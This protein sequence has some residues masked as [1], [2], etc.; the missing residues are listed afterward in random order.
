MLKFEFIAAHC[1]TAPNLEPQKL[2][3]AA[4]IEMGSVPAFDFWSPRANVRERFP[5]LGEA[6]I[7]DLIMNPR[8]APYV[9]KKGAN[10][11]FYNNGRKNVL[12]HPDN[13]RG[14]LQMIAQFVCTIRTH[15]LVSGVRG[16]CW[17]QSS[18]PE[19]MSIGDDFGPV[20]TITW[21]TLSAAVFEAEKR[22][23]T[24]KNVIAAIN[25]GTENCIVCH[26]NL[27]KDIVEFLRDFHNKWHSGAATTFVQH[28]MNIPEIDAQLHRWCK[29]HGYTSRSCGKGTDS[30]R[31]RQWQYLSESHLEIVGAIEDMAT[32]EHARTCVNYFK[33]RNWLDTFKNHVNAVTFFDSFRGKKD[34]VKKVISCLHEFFPIFG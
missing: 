25:K 10:I 11:K 20:Y 30:F 1:C 16:Q 4:P 26:H 24:E 29:R 6:E 12:P 3:E 32:Y 15:S 19:D 8:L 22:Y 27:P 31:G 34:H 23:G 5:G 9:I 13:Q 7:L 2:P 18:A 21:G 14:H 17:V 33:K 28:L